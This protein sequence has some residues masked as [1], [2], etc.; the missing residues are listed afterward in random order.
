MTKISKEDRDK[1]LKQRDWLKERIEIEEAHISYSSM[2]RI[3]AKID[4][5]FNV[6]LQEVFE[7]E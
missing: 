6:I 3:L 7:S 4:F 1:I 5:R 2:K